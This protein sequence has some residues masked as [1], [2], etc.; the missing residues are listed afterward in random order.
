MPITGLT[1]TLHVT[2]WVLESYDSTLE[3]SLSGTHYAGIF[4][5]LLTSTSMFSAWRSFKSRLAES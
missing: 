5:F 2:K 1:M 3:D 4:A